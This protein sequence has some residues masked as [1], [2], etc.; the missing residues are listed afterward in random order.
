MMRTDSQ[1]VSYFF[2]KH[3]QTVRLVEFS[4]NVDSSYPSL[5]QI[6]I[7][8]HIFMSIPWSSRIEGQP[9]HQIIIQV[10]IVKVWRVRKPT[11]LNR[12]IVRILQ[13][14]Q[15]TEHHSSVPHIWRH[16]HTHT[17]HSCCFFFFLLGRLLH[18]NVYNTVGS[19]VPLHCSIWH[20]KLC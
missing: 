5:H 1:K 15:P 12:K 19:S 3:H 8:L 2:S 10:S 11:V 6:I 17:L 4:P 13:Y 18:V 16:T 20:R 14:N 9:L 7:G